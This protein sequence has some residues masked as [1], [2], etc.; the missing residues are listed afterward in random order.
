M[1]LVRFH[2]FIISEIY[3]RRN[4]RQR[5]MGWWRDSAQRHP[6]E[7]SCYLNSWRN[8]LKLPAFLSRFITMTSTNPSAVSPRWRSQRCSEVEWM[9][10]ACLAKRFKVL[11]KTCGFFNDAKLHE[12]NWENF[13]YSL[14]VLYTHFRCRFAGPSNSLHPKLICLDWFTGFNVYFSS[15]SAWGQIESSFGLI[16]VW[17]TRS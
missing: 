1:Q 13:A 17:N 4:K 6:I 15:P 7:S 2:S 11:V 5:R 12:S 3:D 14:L 10:R 16:N 9:K 8:V